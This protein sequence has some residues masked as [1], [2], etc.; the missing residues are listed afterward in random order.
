MCFHLLPWFSSRS[1]KWARDRDRHCL[2]KMYLA[3]L[4]M[5]FVIPDTQV[6]LCNCVL[7]LSLYQNRSCIIVSETLLCAEALLQAHI[8]LTRCSG[9][10][11]W[12]YHLLQLLRFGNRGR[13]TR[14]LALGAWKAAL[15]WKFQ[16]KARH[17]S[18]LSFIPHRKGLL[19][20]RLVFHLL[21]PISCQSNYFSQRK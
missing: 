16:S 19:C 13:V 8:K 6:V 5:C 3:F 2:S 4:A 14:F 9:F 12:S 7:T 15:L 1:L 17:D 11:F 10:Y 20:S 18:S 21:T